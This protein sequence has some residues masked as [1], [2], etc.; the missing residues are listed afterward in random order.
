MPARAKYRKARAPRLLPPLGNR[1]SRRKGVERLMRVFD[2]DTLADAVADD[3][4][5]I[6]FSSGLTM[7][8]TPPKPAR[9]RVENGKVNDNVAGVIHGRDLLES[10]KTTA[11]ARRHDDQLGCYHI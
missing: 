5:K 8:T 6:R 4:A 2:G 7:K 10:A 11:H 9:R 1:K 3:G